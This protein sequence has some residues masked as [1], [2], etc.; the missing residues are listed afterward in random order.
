MLI[1][2]SLFQFVDHI[3]FIS[4]LASQTFTSR[5]PGL[6]SKYTIEK[7]SLF[8]ASPINISRRNL[9]RVSQN[10]DPGFS[11]LLPMLQGQFGSQRRLH[12]FHFLQEQNILQKN[13]QTNPLAS[14]VAHNPCYSSRNT[15]PGTLSKP[16]PFK[17]PLKVKTYTTT[18]FFP[19]RP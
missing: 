10:L 16:P 12:H 4:M 6:V 8:I 18:K 2:F 13:P 7:N 15:S 11:I 14:T 9:S 19:I 17:T 5:Y 3:S 1:V